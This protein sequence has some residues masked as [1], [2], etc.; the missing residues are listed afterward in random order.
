MIDTIV[1]KKIKKKI[2]LIG[3]KI[4]I[5][6]VKSEIVKNVINPKPRKKKVIIPIIR[7][8]MSLL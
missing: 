2:I 7:L 1:I 6:I 8:A 5:P 4:D 3:K